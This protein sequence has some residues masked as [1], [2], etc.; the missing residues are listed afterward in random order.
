MASVGSLWLITAAFKEVSLS[1]P[2]RGL[3]GPRAHCATFPLESAP[4]LLEGTNQLSGGGA[5]WGLDHQLCQSS[6]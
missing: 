4:V 5:T 2:Q 1:T 6:L 3:P